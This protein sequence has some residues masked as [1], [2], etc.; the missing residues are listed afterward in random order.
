MNYA[1]G[2]AVRPRI[3]AVG[4]TA[5][6]FERLR[7]IHGSVTH[8]DE[9]TPFH[10]E[11]HDVLIA[12]NSQFHSH[13]KIAR[14][15]LFAEE[16]SSQG[17]RRM[18]AGRVAAVPGSPA[19]GTA[20]RT[21]APTQ[22]VPARDF[23]IS[24]WARQ[25]KIGPLIE[26]SCVPAPSELYRG[27]R[28]PT[29]PMREVIPLLSESLKRPLILA[30]V[31]EEVSVADGS[32][33]SSV[34]W[35]PSRARSHLSEWLTFAMSHWRR[36]DPDAFPV[37]SE[38]KR[39]AEWSTRG[40][41]DARVEL[42]EFEA[43]ET[44]RQAQVEAR[45]SELTRC[46]DDKFAL[47]EVRRTLIEGTGDALE[48]AVNVAL[49]ELGFRV[50]S[51]DV[52]PEHKGSKREDL[53]VFDGDWV[54]LVEVKGYSA[55]A[56]SNDLFQAA[57]A[58]PPYVL[59]EQ[60]MPDAIWYVVNAYRASDPSQRPA[61]LGAREEDLATFGEVNKGCLMD[62]RDLFRIHQR[63]TLELLSKDEARHLLRS[64]RGRL[65]LPA[66]WTS[67]PNA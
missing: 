41:L 44:L 15:L 17:G 26:S 5:D 11:E 31:F 52:L 45:R 58:V 66:S 38:W 59:R 12:G 18:Q 50:V 20:T 42:A 25:S 6:E 60:R 8:V 35:L 30:G 64:A 10:E 63:V 34:W 9:G 67:S 48:E 28:T 40:E 55:A 2:A 43:G 39:R 32:L 61:A 23:V 19:A 27:V 3:L 57:N 29:N 21:Q 14:R 4:L 47:G 53:R 37:T 36:S 33:M 7:A 62:T 54:S 22:S 65:V 49:Q 16:P 1:R 51:A 46:L 24:D 13:P 56:K